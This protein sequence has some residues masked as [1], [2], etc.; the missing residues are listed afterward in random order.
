MRWLRA[1]VRWLRAL[2]EWRVTDDTVSRAWRK[3]EQI[4]SL[5]NTFHGPTIKWP[6][7][8]E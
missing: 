3:Q 6:I 7:Q 8:K 4:T 1:C 2:N 5:R